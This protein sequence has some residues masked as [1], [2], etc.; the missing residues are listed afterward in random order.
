MSYRVIGMPGMGSTHSA[1]SKPMPCTGGTTH[2]AHALAAP[3]GQSAAFTAWKGG[4]YMDPS[5]VNKGDAIPLIGVQP[6]DHHGGD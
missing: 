2:A 4:I 3:V 6:R 1:M 5:I